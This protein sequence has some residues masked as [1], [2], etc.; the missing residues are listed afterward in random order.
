MRHVARWL[1]LVGL[2]AMLCCL[3]VAPPAQAGSSTSRTVQVRVILP[4][5]PSPQ[6]PG[7]FNA[8]VAAGHLTLLPPGRER[9]TTL[10]RNGGS[11][12][13]LHTE[14]PAL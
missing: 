6:L 5:R 4:E 1:V 12:T 9:T 14:V 11:T 3:C 7:A 2:L 8:A 13:I 10:L